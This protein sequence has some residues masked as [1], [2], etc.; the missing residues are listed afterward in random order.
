M[1]S[2]CSLTRVSS[3]WV[4]IHFNHMRLMDSQCLGVNLIRIRMKCWWVDSLLSLICHGHLAIYYPFFLITCTV[5]TS[6]GKRLVAVGLGDDDQCIED[7]FSAWYWENDHFSLDKVCP[8]FVYHMA[9]LNFCIDHVNTGVT[10]CGLSWI[11]CS[12][13]RMMQLFQLHI[14]QPFW[15]IV[16]CS[17][18]NQMDCPRRT[19]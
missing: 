3:Y 9:F 7:D 12:V 15:S 5:L 16:L 10:M 4:E 8:I 19:A 6:G 14:L 13:M 11:T 17:M 1:N 18:T 2:F